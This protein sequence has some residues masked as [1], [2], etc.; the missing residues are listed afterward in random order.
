MTVTSSPGLTLYAARDASGTITFTGVGHYTGTFS[1]T[2][3]GGGTVTG[4][5]DLQ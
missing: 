4:S 2:L 3:T 1:L 5:F